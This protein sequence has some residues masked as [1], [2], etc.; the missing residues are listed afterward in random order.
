MKKRL[1]KKRGIGEF[2]QYALNFDYS[3]TKEDEFFDTIIECVEGM[4]LRFAGTV[5][6]NK[7]RAI[8][9]QESINVVNCFHKMLLNN[10]ISD[11]S[12]ELIDLNKK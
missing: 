11:F 10:I 5:V 3:V 6:Y 4:N 9:I 8:S 1:R 7:T 12:Y 2:I